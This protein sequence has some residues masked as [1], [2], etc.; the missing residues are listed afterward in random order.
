MMRRKGKALLSLLTRIV[1]ASMVIQTV[2]LR[3]A[4]AFKPNDAGHLGITSE[5]LKATERT[6]SSETLKFSDRAIQQIRDAN[7]DTD[8]L[9]C[10]GNAEFH[11]DDESFSSATARLTSLRA[12]VIS[13]ITA[14]SPDGASARKDLGGALHTLQDFYAHSNWVELGN[15]GIDSRLG[16]STYG[17]L[18]L[19][20]ATC[21]S[22]AGTLGGS[23]L[24]SLTSGWFK[25]PLCVPPTGKCRH[26]IPIACSS[27]LNKDDA[28]RTGY[29]AARSLAVDASKDF[30]NQ[31]LDASGVAG[32]AKA[33]KALMDI[34]STLGMVIDTTGSMGGIIG[35]VKGQVAQIVASVR[36]TDDDLH[37]ITTDFNDPAWVGVFVTQM[38]ATAAINGC[39]LPGRDVGYLNRT[40]VAVATSQKTRGCTCSPM[41]VR[42]THHWPEA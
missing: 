13:K 25:I 21:P 5:A 23:G 14:S 11:F 31:I 39:L 12:N 36:G 37:G 16:R 29:T 32:N 28:G 35:S 9:S 1:I 40:P 17:G 19:S 22:N 30:L 8:C 20:V 2:A 15:A 41:Q 7:K 18:P 38:A 3:P 24:T 26:G 42:K 33:I 6:V 27:G 4:L 34:K 10:Q